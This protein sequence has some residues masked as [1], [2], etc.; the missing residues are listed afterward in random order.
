[1]PIFVCC[2]SAAKILSKYCNFHKI[3]TF[4][5]GSCAHPLH[6]SWLNDWINNTW[7]TKNFNNCIDFH[8]GQTTRKPP[9]ELTLTTLALWTPQTN[10]Q[11]IL[12]AL[13]NRQ[14]F[15]WNCL[16]NLQY[17]TLILSSG[18]YWITSLASF[19]SKLVSTFWHRLTQDVLEKRPLN[20]YSIK[21]VCAFLHCTMTGFTISLALFNRL[22]SPSVLWRCWL[23]GMKG[24][25]P[26]KNWVVGC[27]HGYLSEARCRL[28]YGPADA[29]ATHYLLLQ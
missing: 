2:S 21:P 9:L 23:G 10:H 18:E 27:W 13:G 7:K 12:A 28:V 29:T 5:G 6:Q 1:M 14:I 17:E 4:G 22:N 8:D 19:K 20:R 25:R 3:L 26:V 16:T 15:A 11:N 24:I